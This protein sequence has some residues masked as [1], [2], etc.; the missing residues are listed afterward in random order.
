MLAWYTQDS[1][2]DIH[3]LPNKLPVVRISRTGMSRQVWYWNGEHHGEE[4]LSA[5]KLHLELKE[6]FCI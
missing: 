2:T 4:L 1:E 3:H 5:L 6:M